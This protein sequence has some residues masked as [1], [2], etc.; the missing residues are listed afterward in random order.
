MRGIEHRVPQGALRRREFA[1]VRAGVGEVGEIAAD[2]RVHST[3]TEADRDDAG[4]LLR[5][6]PRRPG[7][8][9]DHHRPR[10]ITAIE[11]EVD[12]TVRPDIELTHGPVGCPVALDVAL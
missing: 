3:G 6:N 7:H 2:E 4:A 10:S 1:E 12:A 5:R 9:P 11:Q 8:R